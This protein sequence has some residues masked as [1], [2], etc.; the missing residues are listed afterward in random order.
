MWKLWVAVGLLLVAVVGIIVVSSPD[1]PNTETN[2]GKPEMVATPM[3]ETPPSP[4]VPL[5]FPP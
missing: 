5:P 3:D 4:A 1:T 2:E